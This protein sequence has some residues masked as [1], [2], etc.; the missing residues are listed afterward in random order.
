MVGL[1][2]PSLLASGSR[3]CYG[4]NYTQNLRAG[5]NEC[6]RDFSPSTAS[7]PNHPVL[8]VTVVWY[9]E[10]RFEVIQALLFGR[11]CPWDFYQ[12]RGRSLLYF[13]SAAVATFSSRS[14]LAIS[15]S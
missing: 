11:E 2:P 8:P 4:I 14:S 3:H 1:A 9:A 6:N 15:S 5:V 10:A 13:S 7:Y 12:F